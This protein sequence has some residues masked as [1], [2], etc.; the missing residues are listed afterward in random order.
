[1]SFGPRA[2]HKISPK[3]LITLQTT[4]QRLR[5]ALPSISSIPLRGGATPYMGQKRAADSSRELVFA[6]WPYVAVYEVIEGKVYIKGVRH[7][8]RDSTKSQ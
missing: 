6:P 8:A 1:M 3:S 2:P 7:T 5:G 4:V